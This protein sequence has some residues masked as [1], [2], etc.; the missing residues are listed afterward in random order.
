MNVAQTANGIWWPVVRQ[1]VQ[2]AAGFVLGAGVLTESE[3]SIIA[4][5]VLAVGNVVWMV[6]A[7]AK[8]EHP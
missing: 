3:V 6:V 8:A 7:R 5:L 4:G 2:H 1:M